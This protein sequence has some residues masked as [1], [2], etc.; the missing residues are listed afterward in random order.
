MADARADGNEMEFKR[1]SKPELKMILKIWR[2]A[3]NS[4]IDNLTL[5]DI[6]QKLKEINQIIS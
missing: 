6:D 2:L 4:D 1:C 5:K 3:P